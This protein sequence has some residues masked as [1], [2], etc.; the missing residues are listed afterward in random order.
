[1][2]KSIREMV[3]EVREVNTALGWRAEPKTFGD[4]VALLHSE[5]AEVLEAYRDYRLT[6]GT[7]T[8]R[9][10][11]AG[12]SKPE[13]V[14]SELADMVIRLFDTCDVEGIVVYELGLE[15]ADVAPFPT[16]GIRSCRMETFGEWISWLHRAIVKFEDTRDGPWMLRA[17]V[18][19]GD[20]FGID[21]TAEYVRKI[22]YNRT[23]PWQH[24]GRTLADTPAGGA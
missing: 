10:N 20:R 19:V 2:G 17:I 21:L 5:A 22:A 18:T 4:F 12:L 16:Y 11:A 15:L 24:G 23:R 13:G 8:E 6:D 7:D 9:W 3:A 1:M 14:G